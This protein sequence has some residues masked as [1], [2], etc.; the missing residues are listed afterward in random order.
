PLKKMVQISP[1]D[2]AR[3]SFDKTNPNTFLARDNIKA[4]MKILDAE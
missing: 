2:L 1:N 4:M 3:A